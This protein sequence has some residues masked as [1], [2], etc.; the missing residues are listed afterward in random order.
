MYKFLRFPGFREI[1]VTLSYDDGS[2]HDARL[3][4]I[5][6]RYGL[7][8]TFN[9]TAN[10]FGMWHL[11]SREDAR[12]LY[13]PAGMEVAM[14]GYDHLRVDACTPADILAEFYRDK[15]KLEDLFGVMMRGGA[16]AYGCY[17]ETA[18]SVLRSLGVSYFRTTDATN[19]FGFPSDPIRLDPT[20]HHGG[21]CIELFERCVAAHSDRE[22][23]RDARFFYLWGHSVEFENNGNWD[24]IENF[25]RRVAAEGDAVWN[26]TNIEA[27]DYITA[28]NRL[29]FSVSG[30]RIYNP[31]AMDVYLLADG[32][33]V[34]AKAGET[35]EF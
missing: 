26:A 9:L 19:R 5:M 10:R 17:N 22:H 1:A 32:V 7:K 21:G 3:I 13:L 11:L 30:R 2:K 14:H 4:E 18:L 15:A 12:A 28:Y 29:I 31:S 6:H 16:Y 33:E 8:G 24:L 35:T 27:I 34:L 23:Q 20:C 25:G